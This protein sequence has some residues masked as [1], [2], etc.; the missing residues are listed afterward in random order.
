MVMACYI[1]CQ[2]ASF[3]RMWLRISNSAA[4]NWEA[5][6]MFVKEAYYVVTS[7]QSRV[8]LVCAPMLFRLGIS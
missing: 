4:D 3:A 5:W 1:Y 2:A 6:C 8:Q 7:S